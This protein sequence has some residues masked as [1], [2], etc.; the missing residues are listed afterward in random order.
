MFDPSELKKGLLRDEVEDDWTEKVSEVVED[1]GEVDE[2]TDWIKEYRD[3][4]I[5]FIEDVEDPEEI[6]TATVLRYI[7]AKSHW[8]ILNTHMQYQAVKTGGPDEAIM[9][10]GSLMSDFLER[11][12]QHLDQDKID[13]VTELLSRPVKNL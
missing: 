5:E 9:A 3:N 10:R 7:E 12:E 2:L 13:S 1:E 8:M 11:L 4:T 6:H